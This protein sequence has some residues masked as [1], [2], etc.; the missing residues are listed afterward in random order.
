MKFSLKTLLILIFIS[1]ITF[2]VASISTSTYFSTK[3][4]MTTHTHQIMS[5]ISTFALDKSRTYML[6][7]RDAAILTKELKGKDARKTFLFERG[8]WLSHGE[9]VASGIPNIYAVEQ[10]EEPPSIKT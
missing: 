3:K 5:N 2:L 1:L 6:A 10:D 8:S 7:A 9:E 4:I